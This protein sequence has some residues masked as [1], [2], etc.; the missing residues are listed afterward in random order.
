MSLSFLWTSRVSAA[1]F[2]YLHCA[3]HEACKRFRV[4]WNWIPNFT[5][6]NVSISTDDLGLVNN[7]TTEVTIQGWLPFLDDQ[8]LLRMFSSFIFEGFCRNFEVIVNKSLRK[9]FKKLGHSEYVFKD[10]EKMDSR[11]VESK[12]MYTRHRHYRDGSRSLPSKNQRQ[13]I[14]NEKRIIIRKKIGVT[15]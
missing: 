14:L 12:E 15:R 10:C 7:S 6:A 1:H 9:L 3:K 8:I 11:L 13:N 2:N 5:A 4:R